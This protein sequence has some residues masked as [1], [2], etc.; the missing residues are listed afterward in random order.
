VGFPIH[1]RMA[2]GGHVAKS[3]VRV[4]QVRFLIRPVGGHCYCQW[5][6]DGII[7]APVFR[8]DRGLKFGSSQMKNDLPKVTFFSQKCDVLVVS[9]IENRGF[10]SSRTAV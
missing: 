1:G 4:C 2:R 7:G 3:F 6:V 9:R 8:L 10:L 5:P